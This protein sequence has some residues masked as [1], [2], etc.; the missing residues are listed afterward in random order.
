MLKLYKIKHYLKNHRLT[1]LTII[2]IF[3]IGL[4]CGGIYANLL[5]S[6]EFKASEEALR[7]YTEGT[8]L[9]RYSYNDEII[10]SG[11]FIGS[12]FLFG[13][14]IITFFI[15]RY[16][17]LTGYLCAFLIKAFSSEGIFPGCTYLFLNL[18]M[19]FPFVMLISRIGFDFSSVFF[20]CIVKKHS[21]PSDFFKNIIIYSAIFLFSLVAIT[22]F[23]RLKMNIFFN[24]F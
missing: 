6:S 2:L 1:H 12:F 11:I 20:N 5:N 14:W 15:F 3:T 17:F 19:I 4:I 23:S 24:T 16:G 18:I 22:F 13:K 21:P 8:S 7:L 9:F 10:L